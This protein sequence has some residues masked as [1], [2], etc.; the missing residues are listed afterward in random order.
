MKKTALALLL[1]LIIPLTALADKT[2]E[3]V[4]KEFENREIAF[5]DMAGFEWAQTAVCALAGDGIVSG[6]GDGTFRPSDSVSKIEFIKM[7]VGACSLLDKS[8]QCLYADVPKDSWGYPYAASAKKCGML[9]IY[10]DK[11]LGANED[12]SREDMAYIA[13]KALEF[14]GFT[15][16]GAAP[17]EDEAQI[18]EYAQDAALALRSEGIIGGFPD[19]TFKPKN[20]ATRAEAAKIIYNTMQKAAEIYLRED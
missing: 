20:T 9:D 13:K 10:S 14:A 18:A 6:S 15:F 7:A 19:G 11:S 4:F 16:G 5:S 3:E 2:A 17:F 12:I 1:A 8:A